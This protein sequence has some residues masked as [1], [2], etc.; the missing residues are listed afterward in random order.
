MTTHTDAY[1]QLSDPATVELVRG[2]ESRLSQA[3]RVFVPESRI[4]EV[5]DR[6]EDGDVIA[7]TSTVAGLDVAH[8]GLALWVDGTLRLMH[9][10]LVG[11]SVQISEV[12]LPQRIEIDRGPGRHHRGQAPGALSCR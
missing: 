12:T 6:I 11:D 4:V 7:A 9:A 5:S 10:P 3:G 1:R 2:T 8:T